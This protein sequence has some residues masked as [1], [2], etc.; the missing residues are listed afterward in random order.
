MTNRI[1]GFRNIQDCSKNRTAY[2]C[3]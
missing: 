3:E 2:R 1:K